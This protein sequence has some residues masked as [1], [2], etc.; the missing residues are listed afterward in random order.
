[1]GLIAMNVGRVDMVLCMTLSLFCGGRKMILFHNLHQGCYF[2]N[3]PRV[4]ALEVASFF[5]S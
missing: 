3:T 1:M 4:A 2:R 5:E